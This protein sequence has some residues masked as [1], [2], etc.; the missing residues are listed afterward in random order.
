MT[1]KGDDSSDFILAELLA[2]PLPPDFHENC[3]HYLP[4]NIFKKAVR[5]DRLG[6]PR[7]NLQRGRSALPDLG[8][9]L[10]QARDD[11]SEGGEGKAQRMIKTNSPRQNRGR[12]PSSAP[13]DR[14][15]LPSTKAPVRDLHQSELHHRPPRSNR[16][17]RVRGCRKTIRN[18]PPQEPPT[19]APD[20]QAPAEDDP[21]GDGGPMPGDTSLRLDSGALPKEVCIRA[22]N[23]MDFA[24]SRF[25]HYEAI[26]KEAIKDWARA[27][28][29]V[30]TDLADAAE[31][32]EDPGRTKNIGRAAR[33]HLGL[34]Q[35]IFRDID[36][37]K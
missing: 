20:D 36:G 24:L 6:P 8:L 33:W 5:A 23:L 16:N 13:T 9:P 27:L 1:I 19:P 10:P 11:N 28:N 12:G 31:A 14:S 7:R 15:S 26:S 22:F 35:L 37:R 32:H 18:S 21:A 2:I 4:G 17:H 34:P 30:A 29:Q 25:E 3:L